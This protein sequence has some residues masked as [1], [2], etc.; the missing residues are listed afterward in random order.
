MYLTNSEKCGIINTLSNPVRFDLS[1]YFSPS[2]T[3]WIAKHKSG[4]LGGLNYSEIRMDTKV[5]SV[6]D[7]E[8]SLDD[9]Y[10][11]PSGKFGREARCK[12]CRKE[13]AKNY[14]QTPEYK[15]KRRAYLCKYK[16]Y[17]THLKYV[18]DYNHKPDRVEHVREYNQLP[19]RKEYTRWYKSTEAGKM[20]DARCRHKR[21]A[22]MKDLPNTLTVQ[23]WEED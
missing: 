2:K 17:P 6:C 3:L 10:A 23:E 1:T 19:A 12:D 5:C 9:F 18:Y 16:L 14:Y 8:K 22:I 21:K 15:E 4:Q 13:Y 20:A 11:F 7:I